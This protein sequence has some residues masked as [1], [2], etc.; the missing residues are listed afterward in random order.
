MRR[1]NWK[2]TE[3]SS[4][5]I[6][7]KD[8][9]QLNYP[10]WL[11]VITCVSFYGSAMSFTMFAT[12]FFT[13]QYDYEP[14]EA[15]RFT[16]IVYISSMI[17]SPIFGWALDLFGYRVHLLIVGSVTLVPLFFCFAFTRIF[18]G[19]LVAFLGISFSLVPAALWPSVALIVEERLIG[20]AFGVLYSVYN[21]A[22]F[23]SP[24]IFGYLRDTTED[25]IAGNCF[26]AALGIVG[27]ISSSLLLIHDRSKLNGILQKPSQ[28][29]PPE[30]F[31]LQF[32]KQHC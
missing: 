11:I 26:F 25:W 8:I 24:I 7:M 29:N 12:E 10:F 2:I 3:G 28:E 13:D 27:T 19:I 16:S 4:E 22:I 5:E 20:T 21:A 14:D 9:K 23:L 18:P 30:I 1:E 6:S 15:A 32:W 31:T 17:A